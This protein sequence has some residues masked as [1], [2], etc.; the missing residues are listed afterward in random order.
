M[1]ARHSRAGTRRYLRSRRHHLHVR[2]VSF[3]SLSAL[4]TQ[5]RADY[6]ANPAQSD[7]DLARVL[8]KQGIT[9]AEQNDNNLARKPVILVMNK[10]DNP[11]RLEAV[12]SMK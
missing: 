6:T 1:V 5:H 7:K 11:N 3:L 4:L 2:H 9:D 8:R 10:V 12:A